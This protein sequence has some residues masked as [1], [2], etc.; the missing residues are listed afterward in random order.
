M[1]AAARRAAAHHHYPSQMHSAARHPC[2]HA[3]A[4]LPRARAAVLRSSLALL[5]GRSRHRAGDAAR[6]AR[7][8]TAALTPPTRSS[9]GYAPSATASSTAARATAQRRERVVRHGASR[10][11]AAHARAA[12]AARVRACP[13]ALRAAARASTASHGPCPTTSPR[14]RRRSSPTTKATDTRPATGSNCSGTSSARSGSTRPKRGRT[15]PPTARP[16]GSGVT[17]AVLDTGVAYANRGRFR[18][19]P[20]FSRLQVRQGL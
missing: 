12:P 17:V 20:D 10:S 9:S 1:P 14:D 19:S 3:S 6:G 7:P 16:A 13:R 15:S 5:D 11:D 8:R 4:S 18:R 2:P